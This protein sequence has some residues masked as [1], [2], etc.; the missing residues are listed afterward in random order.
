M[1]IPLRKSHHYMTPLSASL[2][3]VCP[4][5]PSSLF[6][7]ISC[8]FVFEKISV[9]IHTFAFSSSNTKGSIL[10]MHFLHF[11]FT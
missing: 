11:L 10:Y 4:L 2:H 3:P 7:G 6:S 1:L 9:C 8:V 5:T